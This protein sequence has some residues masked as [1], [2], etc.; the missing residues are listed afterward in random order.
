MRLIN[1]EIMADD[2]TECMFTVGSIVNCVT[3]FDNQIEGEV[4]AFDYQKRLLII[5]SNSSSGQNSLNDVNWINLDFVKDINIKKEVK[6]DDVINT[7]L[8]QLDTQRV[9][10]RAREAVEERKKLTE[11]FNSGVT[12]DGV[13]LYLTLSKTLNIQG[14][15]VIWD[16]ENIIV[17]NCVKI[18]PPYKVENCISIKQHSGSPPESVIFAKKLVEKYWNDQQI[19]NAPKNT[20][21]VQPTDKPPLNNKG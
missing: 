19:Q 13:K 21:S 17:A 7:Q 10:R 1:S 11:A 9:E 6:R 5:K 18:N 14:V 20:N 16:S 3:C 12:P 4:I 15:K 2:I 8:P